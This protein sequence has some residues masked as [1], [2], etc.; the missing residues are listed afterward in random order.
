M[1]E[2]LIITFVT[3]KHELKKKQKHILAPNL[4]FHLPACSTL[5]VHR[6]QTAYVGKNHTTDYR[7]AQNIPTDVQKHKSQKV[8]ILLCLLDV[9]EVNDYEFG[10]RRINGCLYVPCLKNQCITRGE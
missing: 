9:Q 7:S 6:Y 5:T 8:Q 4:V 1:E 3:V 10:S 2:T